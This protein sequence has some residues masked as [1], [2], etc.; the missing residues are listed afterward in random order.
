MPTKKSTTGYYCLPTATRF[1]MQDLKRSTASTAGQ[2]C[3][4]L[5]AL[6]ENDMPSQVVLTS[7]TDLKIDIDQEI[8]TQHAEV[9]KQLPRRRVLGII[10]PHGETDGIL[11]AD[12]VGLPHWEYIR[13]RDDGSPDISE[14][15]ATKMRIIRRR[16]IMDMD[17]EAK[18]A[19]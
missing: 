6:N 4:L 11:P 1:H 3:Y 15:T 13:S 12:G 9:R 7:K 16:E 19:S 18:K 17:K 5:E 10:F 2:Y 14:V 8:D